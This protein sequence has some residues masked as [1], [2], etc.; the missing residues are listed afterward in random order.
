MNQYAKEEESL[1]EDVKELRQDAKQMKSR[2]SDEIEELAGRRVSPF[3]FIYFFNGCFCGFYG[4]L[5]ETCLK[6]VN[7]HESRSSSNV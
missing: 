7:T 1:Q 2:G 4:E 3:F 6:R 5:T